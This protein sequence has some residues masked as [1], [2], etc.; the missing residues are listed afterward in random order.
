MCVARIVFPSARFPEQQNRRL[1]RARSAAPYSHQI[2]THFMKS[3]NNNVTR[4]PNTSFTAAPPSHF[5]SFALCLGSRSASYTLTT[6]DPALLRGSATENHRPPEVK[7][8]ASSDPDPK[9]A[10]DGV[11]QEL[12]RPNGQ[13]QIWLENYAN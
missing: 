13:I 1:T 12:Q 6:N 7:P 4:T 8:T 10:D 5:C 2:G 9:Q 11:F 3:N